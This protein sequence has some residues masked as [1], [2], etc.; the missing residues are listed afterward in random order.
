MSTMSEANVQHVQQC[1]I[2]FAL[3]AVI[4]SCLIKLLNLV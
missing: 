1:A 2:C 4:V 3:F